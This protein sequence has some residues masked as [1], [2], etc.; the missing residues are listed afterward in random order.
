MSARSKRTTVSQ[1]W[2]PAL[3][4]FL[5]PWRR[6]RNVTG[7]L[8]CGSYVTGD[9]SA[10]SDVD[11]Q[12]LL[13][14]G[15]SWEERGN[16]VV[17]GYLFEYFANT[18]ERKRAYF[19]EGMALNRPATAT[20][21]VTGRVIFDDDGG[22]ARLRRDAA[23]VLRRPYAAL[24]R[25]QV[26]R[27]KYADW[28]SLDNL[29]DL[30]ARGVPLAHAYH[31]HLQGIYADYAR[32]LRQPVLPAPQLY[33]YLS[34]PWFRRKYRLEPFP[35]ATFRR[36]LTSALEARGRPAMLASARQLTRHVLRRLGG[37]DIDGWRLRV[38]T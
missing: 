8:V 27:T 26:E 23:R 29:E 2:E 36:L 38:T 24:S 11:V 30:A 13:A 18:A 37:F 5:R 12:I 35:D 14:D 1:S 10:H 4:S 25:R 34:D 20:M 21:F 16:D 33:R 15:T 9:A 28:D 22:V 19:Q 6:R 7:A 31:A 3:E 17:D 32:F